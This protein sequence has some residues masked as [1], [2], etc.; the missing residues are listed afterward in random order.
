M[1]K[2]LLVAFVIL[3]AS[4]NQTKIAYINVEDLMKDYEATKVLEEKLK[5][6]QEEMA[7]ELG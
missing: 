7:K 3:F 5:A 1:K 6:R 4:C 2:F